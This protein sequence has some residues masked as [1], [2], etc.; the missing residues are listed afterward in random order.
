MSTKFTL[1][2]ALAVAATVAGCSKLLDSRV[3]RREADWME[4]YP[5]VGTLVPFEGHSVHVLV[6]GQPRGSAPDVVLIHG[7]NGNLRD[8]TFDMVGRL[9]GRYRV[10]AVDRPGLGWTDSWGEADSD[11]RE[12]ARILR[13]AL[14]SVGVRRPIVVGHSY[15]ASV[16]MAWALQAPDQTAGVV[17]IA[18]ATHPW[19]G[20]LGLWY[21]INETPV[22]TPAR[23]LVAAFASQSAIE[24]ALESVFAPD[25][26]PAGYP[27]HFGTGLSLRRE[28]QANNTRQVNAL[29]ANLTEM[30][31]EYATLTVPIELLHGTADTTVGLE[32]HSRRMA[33]EVASAHLTEI[34]GAGH[35]PHHSHPDEVV[36]A[37][38]RIRARSER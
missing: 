33:A 15:G 38:D 4:L 27:E 18:G 24:S 9:Q 22:A 31:P 34:E 23:T 30:Q 19:E 6:E 16:A 21:R 12:Q 13:G 20:G 7:A 37:I 2:L 25:P 26:V 11:P 35:M 29:L 32:I 5:P 3:D 14:A 28:S 17:L 10:I 1:L 8:F 36:A